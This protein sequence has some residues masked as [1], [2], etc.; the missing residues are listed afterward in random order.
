MRTELTG[1][2]AADGFRMPAEW[3]PHSGCYLAWPENTYVWREGAKP[4]QRAVA[5]IA[6]AIA[7]VGEQV[8]VTVSSAQYKH[9]R[10]VLSAAVRVVET[11]TVNVWSRDT[12]PTFVVDDR[13]GLRGVKWVFN[14]YGQRFPEWYLDD[15]Y[16]TKVLDLERLDQYRAPVVFEGGMLD[17]DGLGTGIVAEECVLDPARNPHPDREMIA[18]AVRDFAA[19]HKLLWLP[20]GLTDDDTRGHIDNMARFVAP[21]HL[22][23]AWTDDER[24]PQFARSAAALEILERETDAN[25]NPLTVTKIPIPGPL[26]MT[27]EENS[28]T[29]IGTSLNQTGNR[30]A[31][32]YC[33]FYLANGAVLVPQ[34]DPATDDEAVAILGR[35]F[36]ER[37]TVPIPTRD[38]LLGGGNIHCA[39]RQL[40]AA[41]VG[42]P[43]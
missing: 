13:G 9:A 16:A 38:L 17:V 5:A 26:Y 31:G 19:V 18:R 22:L 6:N 33:N 2:P 35:M 41:L 23:L 40:P 21:G 11:S 42:S 7:E 29:D 10:L 27:A 24:D 25:G 15:A 3:E 32:S 37:D 12:A 39:T 28:G 20:W 43:R 8:T 1:T 36:P 30:L 4:V 34:L 14:G